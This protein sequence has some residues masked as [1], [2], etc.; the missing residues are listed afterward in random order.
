MKASEVWVENREGICLHCRMTCV[1]QS[2]QSILFPVPV[3]DQS[4]IISFANF[5]PLLIESRYLVLEL[6]SNAFSFKEQSVSFDL[7]FAQKSVHGMDSIHK[8]KRAMTYHA[9]IA[10]FIL[11]IV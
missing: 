9:H 2:R 8:L 7:Q 1:A 11:K 3:I 6:L 5:A 10:R 4:E